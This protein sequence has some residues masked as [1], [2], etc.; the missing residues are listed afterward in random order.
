MGLQS[1]FSGRNE[2]SYCHYFNLTLLGFLLALGAGA[3][4]YASLVSAS[5]GVAVAPAT[6]VE[7]LYAAIF[8]CSQV[9][10]ISLSLF[11]LR[12]TIQNVDS[13]ATHAKDSLLPFSISLGIALFAI[14]L[15]QYMAG[16][17][18][19]WAAEL[20]NFYN[21]TMAPI[22]FGFIYATGI[23]I[24]YLPTGFSTLLAEIFD[25]I[26]LP[27][28]TLYVLGSLA[29]INLLRLLSR[30]WLISFLGTILICLH[31]LSIRSGFEYTQ[32]SYLMPL[33]FLT[34]TQI[35]KTR[36]EDNF[37]INLLIL[38][39]LS[40]TFS[41][42]AILSYPILILTVIIVYLILFRSSLN[43]RL[44]TGIALSLPPALSI[45]IL[46]STD[47]FSRFFLQN[48][49]FQPKF[50]LSLM[51]LDWLRYPLQTLF[52]TDNL[53]LSGAILTALILF[54]PLLL[55]FKRDQESSLRLQAKVACWLQTSG[56]LFLISN[57]L[58]TTNY[59]NPFFSYKSTYPGILLFLLGFSI[60]ASILS[61][62]LTPLL[63]HR[64]K[65][66]E[67]DKAK[68][69]VTLVYFLLAAWHLSPPIY[70]YKV[71]ANSIKE[72]ITKRVHSE[73]KVACLTIYRKDF[74]SPQEFCN[75]VESV[76]K[77]YF[78]ASFANNYLGPLSQA[79]SDVQFS[80]ITK[81]IIMTNITDQK[82]EA[83][84]ADIPRVTGQQFRGGVIMDLS[85][86]NRDLRMRVM[87][88]LFPHADLG[89]DVYE[90][91]ALIDRKRKLLKTI[92]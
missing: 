67:D 14:L 9:F 39:A 89:N 43:R 91:S 18:P 36:E 60:N 52:F 23:A 83:I 28:A 75:S 15:S 32:S 62:I 47:L 56:I 68:F 8:F 26:R 50:T 73:D 40:F 54:P 69:S 22:K 87:T 81:L 61:S 7:I 29:A 25:P 58:V 46:C 37:P 27:A 2:S 49:E 21:A 11:K 78:S 30:N 4:I 85:A 1:K 53:F 33:L 51:T 38:A 65:K 19:L 35:L 74:D 45:L 72:G 63:T 71:F 3:S 10:L 48:A 31:P 20:D 17:N 42:I 64:F 34:I 86:L 77:H 44:S 5:R 79:R 82:A 6:T 55:Y 84:Y 12:T 88:Q 66:I 13:L 59:I 41:A 70:E 24:G 16:L 76:M 80:A 57:Y 90:K 92:D